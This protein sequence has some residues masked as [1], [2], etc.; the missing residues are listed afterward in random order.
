[1][2]INSCQDKYYEFQ[3]YIFKNN[4]KVEFIYIIKEGD[5][6]YTSFE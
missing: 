5:I 1:M 6:R 3:N 2:I 4:E